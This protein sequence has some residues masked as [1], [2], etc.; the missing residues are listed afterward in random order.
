MCK[1]NPVDGQAAITAAIAGCPDGSTVLFPAGKTYRQTDKIVVE[2]RKDLV[3]D[4]NGSTFITSAPNDASASMYFARPN[5]MVVE[6]ANVTVRNMTI[7]GNLPSGPRGIIKGNQYNAGIVIYGGN[8]VFVNDVS[9]YSV[10]GEFVIANPSGFYYGGGALDGEV[11]TNVRVSRLTGAHAARQCVAVTAAHGFWLEDSTMSDCY[12]NGVDVEPDV[13]GVPL[14]DIHILRNTISDYY[15]SAL[16]VPTAYRSGDVDGV[17][18]R[19]NKTTT[20]SDT[21]YPAV[22]MGGVQE[23]SFVLHNIVVADNTLKTLYDGVVENYVGSGRV[24]GN[25]ITV[26]VSPNWCGP[27]RGVP[28]RLVSSPNVSVHSNTAKGY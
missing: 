8:G 28:V 4:G 13:A 5:W 25:T 23:N 3:I 14:R 19:G 12:Q 20:P 11:P 2:G 15:F 18:I 27:P 9:V 16:T 6:G 24:T 22:L 10:F 26:T 21:C 17:E 7:R 1:I